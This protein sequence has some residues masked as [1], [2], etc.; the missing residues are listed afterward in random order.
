VAVG[1]MMFFSL[2]TAFSGFV[3]VAGQPLNLNLAAFFGAA[4][5]FFALDA[6]FN[7]RSFSILAATFMVCAVAWQLLRYAEV[8]TGDVYILTPAG[9]GLVLL[10]AYR[11]SLLERLRRAGVPTT[12]FVCANALLLLALGAG[13]LL[14]LARLLDGRTLARDWVG[15]PLGLAG[16][17]VVAVFLAAQADWRRVYL[18]SA[19]AHGVVAALTLTFL[20]DLAFEQKLEI[21]VVAAGVA[22]LVA[23]H[24]GWYREAEQENDTVTTSLILGSIMVALPLLITVIGLRL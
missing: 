7:R 9:L 11:F 8:E 19:L 20:S 4:A 21:A 5:L 3:L 24:A 15:L 12:A 17:A 2:G 6:A 16:C 14:A 1:V 18:I 13:L 10:A 23:G 22:L